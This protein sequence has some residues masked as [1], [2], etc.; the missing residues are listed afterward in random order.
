MTMR[1][2]ASM[3]V[4]LAMAGSL[5]ATADSLLWEIGTAD[6]DTAEFALARDLHREYRDDPTFLVGQSAPAEWPYCHPGPSD[7]WAGARQHT[8]TILFG[9]KRVE[10]KG[11][12]YL[13]FDLVNTHAGAPPKLQVTVNG[14][15]FNHDTPRGG[16]DASILGDPS[17]GKEHQFAI[18]VPAAYLKPGN[19]EILITNTSGSW[20]LYDWLGFETPEGVVSGPLQTETAVS[21]V[22]SAPILVERDGALHQTVRV[23]LRH[24]G[25]PIKATVTVADIVPVALTL[26]QGLKTIDVPV[27]AVGTET[28]VPITVTVGGK[29]LAKQE[30][31][32]AP[33][34][35]WTVYLLHHTHL[36]IGYTHLQTDVEKRQWEHLEQAIELAEKT[37]DYPEGSRFKWLPEGLWA[38]D[39]Y[40]EHATPEKQDA[41]VDAVRKGW[42]GLDALYGNQLTALCRP[43]ELIRL[44]DCARRFEKAYDLTIDSAMITDV[45]GYTWGIVPVLAQ[46]GVK[47]LSIGPNVGHRIGYTLSA[48]GDRPFY[49]VSPS[50]QE[51]VLCW[52]AGTAYSWFHRAPLRDEKGM[53]DYLRRLDASDYPYDMVQV[54]YNIGGDNGPP[55]PEIADFV[56]DWNTRY[57]YP[58]LVLATTSEMF[59]AFEAE[60]GDQVPSVAGDFTPYWEDGAASSARETAINREAAER[61]VQ[62][63]T[64]WT[65]LNPEGYPRDDFYEA[66]RNVL[67]YD[68]HTWGAHNSISEPEV[69][70]VKG[71]WAIKQAF[72]LDA[73]TQSRQL[74]DCALKGVRSDDGPITSVL[75]FNAS[76]FPRTDLVTIPADWELAGDRVGRGRYD[77]P[78]QRLSTGELVFVAH[79]VPPMGSVKYRIGAGAAGTSGIPKAE[80]NTLTSQMVEVDINEETGAIARLHYKVIDCDLVDAASGMGLNEYRYVA[81]RD[82]KEPQESGAPTITVKET[83]PVVVSLLI[84]SDAPGCHKLS[85]EVRLIEGLNRV[86]IINTLDR[87]N[88]YDQEGV[89]FAFPFNVPDGV[90]RMDVPWAVVRPEHDQLPGACKNYFTVQR[91]VDVSNEEY[92]VLLATPDAPLIEVGR[93]TNDPRSS[94]G[95]IKKLEPTSTVYSYVM[96]NYWETNYKASQPG[97]TTFRYA[98]AFHAPCG[99]EVAHRFGEALG[100]P[101][102]AVPV[103]RDALE[104]PSF[105]NVA[106]AGVIV[107][108][109]KP[110]EDGKA[111]IARLYG[112]SGRPEQATIA[113]GKGERP[114]MWLSDLTEDKKAEVDGSIDVPPYGMVTLRIA[115]Q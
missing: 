49:W 91:W 84:E 3:G 17:A 107:T 4:V 78:S 113:L 31:S 27:P 65:M 53:F 45:P 67:L 20:M 94:V 101:L 41:F 95:W 70:F 60:Y 92:G 86:E 50:G 16:P 51:K 104:Y 15:A 7:A 110:S 96:N 19:N 46:G 105:M 40:M 32:L 24:L 66:W 59:H 22:T 79:D 35:K 69:E 103:A 115:R 13:R 71:Q 29:T 88:V 106:P 47:Y 43:E 114:K 82:P 52:V 63:E 98:I 11:R 14:H 6:N 39:S 12:C 99:L 64:L 26:Q 111:W 42:V 77:V 48:W 55:D 18:T 74:L 57:A 38:M 76:S 30:V 56:K 112:A 73:D 68:E 58:R 102:V 89:H 81:G 90:I 9:L 72:A 8:F 23:R 25:E 87:E 61:L 80:G 21:G 75:V 37:A 109:L 36:D 28:T 83:G 2:W 54:R 34:R 44:T 10:P 97:V 93:I 100:Q 5:A 108:A 1:F 62:A 33:V 85:R